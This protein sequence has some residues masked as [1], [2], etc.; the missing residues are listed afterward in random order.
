MEAQAL[1]AMAYQ[2]AAM[3]LTKIGEADLAWMAA[4]RG[5]AAAQ[6]SGNLV[7]TGSLFRSVAH[8]LLANGRPAAARDLVVAS[9]GYLED[10]LGRRLTDAPVDLRHS[11]P[12]RSDGCGP[13]RGP[14]PG[15]RVPR[16]GRA[17]GPASRT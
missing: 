14:G 6:E 15:E 10:G 2:G 1:L 3:V 5:L 13:D 11:L 16:R 8:C 4:D 9:A 7:V 17:D 12:R